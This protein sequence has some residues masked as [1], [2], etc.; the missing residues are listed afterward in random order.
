MVECTPGRDVENWNL[1]FRDKGEVVEVKCVFHWLASF[2]SQKGR[3]KGDLKF[4]HFELLT[5]YRWRLD[6]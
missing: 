3:G 5:Q 4:Q 6:D 1:G 2:P